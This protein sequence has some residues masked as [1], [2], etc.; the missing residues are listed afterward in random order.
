MEQAALIIGSSGGIG[1]ALADAVEASGR[2][3]RVWRAARSGGADLRLDITDENSI[4]DAL[5]PFKAGPPLGLVIVATGLL[6]AANHRPERSFRELDAGWL[7][8]NFRVNAIGPALIAKH[9]LPLLPKDARAVFAVLSAR[10]GSISDNALGGWHAYR[11]SKAALN[12]LTK[13]F[14]TELGRT[15]KHAICVALHP[16]TVNTPLSAP[17]Q[18]HVSAAKLFSPTYAAS[19][20]LDVLDGLTSADSGKIFAWDGAEINP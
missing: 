11:A 5:V 3:G 16:G 15:H 17:F 9:I 7:A 10:V 1:R 2:Y 4:I 19:A 6:H 20:L 13:N 12:M 8:E 14:A 18:S